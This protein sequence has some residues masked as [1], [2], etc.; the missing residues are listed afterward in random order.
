MPPTSRFEVNVPDE[1]EYINVSGR[2]MKSTTQ[3][4]LS[5]PIDES[6]ASGECKV[7]QPVDVAAGRQVKKVINSCRMIKHA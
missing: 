2:V 4:E 3:K 6:I 5:D 1:L 7:Q